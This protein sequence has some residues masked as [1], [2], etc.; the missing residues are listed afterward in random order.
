MGRIDGGGMMA[1]VGL[2]GRAHF[3]PD[4]ARQRPG[5]PKIAAAEAYKDMLYCLRHPETGF[6]RK[7]RKWLGADYDPEKCDLE[8]INKALRRLAREPASSTASGVRK[9]ARAPSIIVAAGIAEKTSGG[10]GGP[11]PRCRGMGSRE[12]G[13]ED[14]LLAL[15]KSLSCTSSAFSYPC[16]HGRT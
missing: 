6:G 3:H 9:I 2:P 4:R 8:T 15:P 5:H 14:T 12:A 16:R 11:A 1:L 7:W 10:T 13:G